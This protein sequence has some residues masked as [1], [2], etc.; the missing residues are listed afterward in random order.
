MAPDLRS[1]QPPQTANREPG[2]TIAGTRTPS[3]PPGAHAPDPQRDMFMR[4]PLLCS[5]CHHTVHRE[6]WVIRVDAGAVW[7]IPPPHVDPERAPR[8]GG[9]A[10]FEL[11]R[12]EA[13]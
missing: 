12:V 2:L 9:R 10:R 13:A 6:G 3:R 5:F 1:P 8:L 11:D 4:Q 7:F